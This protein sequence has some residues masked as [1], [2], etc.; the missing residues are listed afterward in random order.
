MNIRVRKKSLLLMFAL[1]TTALL[2]AAC[3]GGESEDP[4]QGD[5]SER[6]TFTFDLSSFQSQTGSTPAAPGDPVP[7]GGVEA[8]GAMLIVGPDGNLGPFD[9]NAVTGIRQ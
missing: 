1:F 2:L 6:T 9:F 3:G 4:P 5:G 8:H 7:G